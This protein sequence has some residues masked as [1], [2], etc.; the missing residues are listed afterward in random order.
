[1]FC[2]AVF[3]LMWF[4]FS[5]LFI[6][7]PWFLP[8]CNKSLKWWT[9]GFKI[10]DTLHHS[11]SPSR[12]IFYWAAKPKTWEQVN[13]KGVIIRIPLASPFLYFPSPCFGSALG[14]NRA[15][16]HHQS[17]E[18]MQM[19][20]GWR[21]TDSCKLCNSLCCACLP[22]IQSVIIRCIYV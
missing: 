11:Y 21:P 3:L 22:I 5:G 20:I 7:L 17:G 9:K 12:Q 18:G 6:S 14:K 2:K 10:T 8:H 13:P 15:C 1:M 16:T 4:L 19:G